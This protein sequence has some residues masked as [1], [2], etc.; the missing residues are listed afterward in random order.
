M[1]APSR[2][3]GGVVRRVYR[4]EDPGLFGANLVIAV[5]LFLIMAAA[6]TVLFVELFG[7]KK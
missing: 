2:V 3:R 4:S 7:T 6:T 5:I 1:A